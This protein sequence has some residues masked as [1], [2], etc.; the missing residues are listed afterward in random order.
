MAKVIGIKNLGGTGMHG[1]QEL[2]ELSKDVLAEQEIT[3]Q[4]KILDQFFEKL[5]KDSDKVSYGEAEVENRLSRGAVEKLIISKS[6][7]IEKVKILKKL[8]KASSTEIYIVTKE[9]TQGV[10]FD[11]LGGVGA[12]LRFA[13]MD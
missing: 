6:L 10:Q 13:I 5:A 3:K 9:T 2:V 8:A 12:I 11:N 4:K 7:P 1:L